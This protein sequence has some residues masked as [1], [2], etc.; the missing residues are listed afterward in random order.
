MSLSI[1]NAANL[2]VGVAIGYPGHLETVAR[3]QYRKSLHHL[4]LLVVCATNVELAYNDLVRQPRVAAGEFLA[5]PLEKL[6]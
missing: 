3:I 4:H 5:S 6:C 2:A 1:N